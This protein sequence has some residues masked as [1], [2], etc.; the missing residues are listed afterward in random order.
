MSCAL[1]S[2]VYLCLFRWEGFPRQTCINHLCDV[3]SW[4]KFRLYNNSSGPALGGASAM[5]RNT[6]A[7]K[8]VKFKPSWLFHKG[9]LSLHSFQTLMLPHVGMLN[10]ARSAFST[11]IQHSFQ[12][13]LQSFYQVLSFDNSPWAG[14]GRI[15]ALACGLQRPVSTGRS[16]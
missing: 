14:L 8:H 4:N 9:C 10:S 2:S 11:F 5:G 7:S 6:M 16:S 3:N 13:M 15:L 1:V 12:Q